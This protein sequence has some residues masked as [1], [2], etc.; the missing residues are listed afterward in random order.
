MVFI[1]LSKYATPLWLLGGIL[2][3]LPGILGND[4]TELVSIGIVFIVI[5]IA[6]RI[7]ITDG[8]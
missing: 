8:K 6:T 7:R 1:F 3:M 5:G 2:L 4:R